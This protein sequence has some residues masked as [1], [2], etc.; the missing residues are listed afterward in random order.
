MPRTRASGAKRICRAGLIACLPA[1]LSLPLLLRA[2]EMSFLQQ[3]FEGREPLWTPG[4]ADVTYKETV[5]Q[6]TEETAHE[7][8]RSESIE[9][10]AQ[11]GSYIYYTYPIG[12]APISEDMLTGLW[13]KANR[14]GVQL[15][16][17]LVLPHERDPRN[18]ELP[19]TTLLRGDTYQTTGHWQH[20]ELRQ[21]V[22]L[23][24]QQQQLLRAE[25]RRDVTI[26]DSYVD[27]VLLNVYGGP[28]LTRVWV[29]DLEVGPIV[30]L[31]KTPGPAAQPA[32][33]PGREGPAIAPVRHA[34]EVKVQGEKLVVGGRNFFLRGIRHTGTPLKTLREA[35]FNTV[36]FDESTEP[37]TVEQAVNLGF[38][39]VPMLAVD[40]SQGPGRGPAG[41][42]TSNQLVGRRMARFLAQDAVLAWD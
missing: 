31:K 8:H 37:E 7:G 23:T 16:A 5:H 21:P 35:G 14:P 12:R 27:L 11:Q 3:G 42:L 33:T 39:L 6:L 10:Q 34:A 2:Q 19:L 25:L 15:L 28:G 22:R 9:V 18:A 40:D 29:D 1:L 30:D 36:W 17:R 20:L 26:A 24:T 41:Q 4:A 32:R 38:W 13:I